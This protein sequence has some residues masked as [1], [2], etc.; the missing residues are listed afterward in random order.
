MDGK[1]TV[2]GTVDKKSFDTLKAIED[3]A[4][5]FDRDEKSRAR[6]IKTAKIVDC[7]EL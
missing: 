6:I 2:F 1:H 5:V 4:E 3:C 7:G